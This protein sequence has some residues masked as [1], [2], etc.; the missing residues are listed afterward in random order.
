MLMADYE[1]VADAVTLV[2]KAWAARVTWAEDMKAINKALDGSTAPPLA[3][4]HALR[5]AFGSGA[6]EATAFVA[7][8]RKLADRLDPPPPPPPVQLIKEESAD[9]KGDQNAEASGEAH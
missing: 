8:S 2:G 6:S 1:A 3:I 5:K 4:K 7:E 9:E